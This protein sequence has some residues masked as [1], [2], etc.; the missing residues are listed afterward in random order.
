MQLVKAN[1]KTSDNAGNRESEEKNQFIK[2]REENNKNSANVDENSEGLANV[3]NEGKMNALNNEGKKC[4]ED[5]CAHYT[6]MH[7]SKEVKDKVRLLL[8][9]GADPAIISKNGFSPLHLASY[10][11][12]IK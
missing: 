9:K 4:D 8:Q 3:T 1:E 10:K 5:K 6:K 12:V 7:S 2:E 11:V